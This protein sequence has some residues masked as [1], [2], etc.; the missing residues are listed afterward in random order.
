M[1]SSPWLIVDPSNRLQADVYSSSRPG[2]YSKLTSNITGLFGATLG[3]PGAEVRPLGNDNCW[4]EHIKLD[5]FRWK[6]D[7]YW[8][9]Y[10][11]ESWNFMTTDQVMCYICAQLHM[12]FKWTESSW[13]SDKLWL[14]VYLLVYE[15]RK[16]RRCYNI[17]FNASR[18]LTEPG[19][20]SRRF[21]PTFMPKI[22]SSSPLTTYF[23]Q[24]ERGKGTWRNTENLQGEYFPE[25]FKYSGGMLSS[26]A[27]CFMMTITVQY[28]ENSSHCMMLCFNILANS[29]SLLWPSSQIHK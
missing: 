24:N 16:S 17:D 18:P 5:A 12:I 21:P 23:W 15:K 4:K 3:L 6:F 7:H 27:N 20:Y 26:K 10:I 1:W 22:P 2:T 29:S 11:M 9:Y 14:H 13:K 25:R 19:I 28:S 8:K